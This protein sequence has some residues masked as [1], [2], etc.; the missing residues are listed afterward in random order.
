MSYPLNKLSNAERQIYIIIHRNKRVKMAELARQ[1]A[2]GDYETYEESQEGTTK[3][4]VRKIIRDLR[5]KHRI[6]IM[7]DIKGY[8]LAHVQAEAVDFMGRIEKRLVSHLIMYHTFKKMFNV[9]CSEV[10]EQLKLFD[11]DQEE[12]KSTLIQ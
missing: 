3:R 11:L 10:E 5:I 1:T 9:E 2:L 6:P 4:K 12:A 7:S 8:F